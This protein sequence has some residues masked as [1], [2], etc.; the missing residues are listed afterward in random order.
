MNQRFTFSKSTGTVLEYKQKI[1]LK[2]IINYQQ[3]ITFLLRSKN[4][5]CSKY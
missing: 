4:E 2:N 1:T 3:L 5:V